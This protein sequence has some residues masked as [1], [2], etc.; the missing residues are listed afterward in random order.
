[1]DSIS[2]LLEF[3]YV[4]ISILTFSTLFTGFYLWWVSTVNIDDYRNARGTFRRW[5]SMND[6]ELIKSLLRHSGDERDSE[7]E[8]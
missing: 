8:G 6:G 3:S 7:V 1:M 4:V 5:K 2:N